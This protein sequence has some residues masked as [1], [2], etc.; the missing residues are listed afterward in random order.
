MTT[1][2]SIIPDN[3]PMMDFLSWR[4]ECAGLEN[5]QVIT[6]NYTGTKRTLTAIEWTYLLDD[7]I[8]H[9]ASD[10]E[11][12]DEPDTYLAKCSNIS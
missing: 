4:T 2:E 7:N 8:D 12:N 3:F 9:L 10:L 5:D 1:T 11:D 6:S